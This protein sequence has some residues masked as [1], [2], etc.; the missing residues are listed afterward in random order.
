M[1]VGQTG[2]NG[3]HARLAV[4]KVT[5]QEQGNDELDHTLQ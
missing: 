1:V 2:R 4:E 5:E 3:V